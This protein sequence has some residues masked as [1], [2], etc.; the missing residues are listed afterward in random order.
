MSSRTIGP[1]MRVTP[2]RTSAPTPARRS[3]EVSSGSP[4]PTS[5]SGPWISPRSSGGASATKRVTKRCCAPKALSALA[6]TISLSVEA[7]A[8]GTPARRA[9]SVVPSAATTAK[10]APCCNTSDSNVEPSF[11]TRSARCAGVQG[12]GAGEAVGAGEGGGLATGAGDLAAPR[13]TQSARAHTPLRA[14]TAEARAFKCPL[15][16]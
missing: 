14:S 15:L 3:F 12:G 6:A 5:H 9:K 4:P 1:S 16:R 11:S 8:T 10:P 7:G 2:A 13:R